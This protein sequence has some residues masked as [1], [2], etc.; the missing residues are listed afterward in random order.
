MIR[1]CK[2]STK[3]YA[4]KPTQ[5]ALLAIAL[6]IMLI[7]VLSAEQKNV[8]NDKQ[9]VYQLLW[10]S[11]NVTGTIL[12]NGFRMAT[13]DG[14]TGS[15]S[16]TLN[17]WLTGKNE[18]S[19][20]IMKADLANKSAFLIGLS[21]ISSGEVFDNPAKG[22][23]FSA[24]KNDKD[25][26][27]DKTVKMAHKFK[28]DL[29]FSPNLVKTQKCSEKDAITYAMKVRDLFEK[30]DSASLVKEFSPKLGDYSAAFPGKNAAGEFKTYLD[31]KLLKGR[32]LDINAS[33]VTAVKVGPNW[34]LW[35]VV[36][37]EGELIRI[38]VIGGGRL[39]IPLYIGKIKGELK[40]VR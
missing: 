32:V 10:K 6:C 21:K 9:V 26:V 23:V 20:D 12:I 36:T 2:I 25:F 15:G 37:E 40:V 11:E 4:M 14:K 5:K 8:K 24:E 3:R 28:T 35:H 33:K 13:I 17:V 27:K 7:P 34:N 19:V 18:L 39:E 31:S 22:N 30:K 29:D 1:T 38:G 16:A